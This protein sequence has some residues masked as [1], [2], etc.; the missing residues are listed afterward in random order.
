MGSSLDAT[1]VTLTKMPGKTYSES[2]MDIG[3]SFTYQLIV[4][5]PAI[6]VQNSTDIT[7]ELFAITPQTG[8]FS[9]LF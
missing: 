1:I 4:D 9:I 3:N 2:A 7:S 5:L 8:L 6:A